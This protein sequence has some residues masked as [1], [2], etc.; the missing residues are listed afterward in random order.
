[1]KRIVL[2]GL[3]MTTA[4]GPAHI[5]NYEPKRREYKPIVDK[6]SQAAEREDGSLWAPGVGSLVTDV[7]AYRTNDIVTVRVVELASAKRSAGTRTR[8]DGSVE[9]GG[10]VGNLIRDNT[11]MDPDKLLY[12]SSGTAHDASGRTTR[13]DEVR[14]NV[15]A[16]ITKV[17]PNGNLFLEG[18]RVILVNDEEHHFYVSGVARPADIAKDNSIAS[19]QLADAQIEFVGDGVMSEGQKPGWLTRLLNYINPL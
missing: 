13:D 14:F 10:D 2:I 1:M 4:C 6:P 7:R 16:T 8:R 9:L 3:L 5:N 15:A 17:L 18:H 12:G 11:A 19:I